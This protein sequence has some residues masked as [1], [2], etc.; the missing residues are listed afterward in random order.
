M[1]KVVRYCVQP[2]ERR[3]GAVVRGD[4]QQFYTLEEAQRAAAVM[5]K[6]CERVELYQVTGWPVQD[7][8]DRPKRVAG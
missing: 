4:A 6:R 3:K 5:R 8:W 1:F 2:Y 7:L